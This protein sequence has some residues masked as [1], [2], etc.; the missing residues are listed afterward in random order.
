[1][2]TVGHAIARANEALDEVDLTSGTA[3]A[4]IARLAASAW[5][6][7]SQ[8]RHLMVAGRLHPAR[9]GDVVAATVVATITP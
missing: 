1:M 5:Q 8:H 9:A 7:L 6:I 4:A 2:G 3:P